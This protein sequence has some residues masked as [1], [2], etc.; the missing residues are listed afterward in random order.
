MSEHFKSLLDSIF[1]SNW[2]TI[3]TLVVH[4]DTTLAV[5]CEFEFN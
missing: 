2:M 4:A 1:L 3:V 5:S